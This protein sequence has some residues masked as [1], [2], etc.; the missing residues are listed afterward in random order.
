MQINLGIVNF[1]YGRTYKIALITIFVTDIIEKM[2]FS[3]H[4]WY[5]IFKK[6][7]K[8]AIFRLSAEIKRVLCTRLG[9]IPGC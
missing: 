5:V 3:Y 2:V 7:Q 4:H 8:M 1:L 6:L 9:I